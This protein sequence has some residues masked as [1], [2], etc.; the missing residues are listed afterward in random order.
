MLLHL[1]SIE[2]GGGGGYVI[3]MLALKGFFFLQL[4]GSAIVRFVCLI[5]SIIN[6]FP[7]IHAFYNRMR[8]FDS[9][10]LQKSKRLMKFGSVVVL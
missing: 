1:Y 5:S 2:H 8:S 4:R 6:F 10:G 3:L 7:L 9:V